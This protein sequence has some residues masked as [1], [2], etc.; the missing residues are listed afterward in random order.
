M[1]R[2]SFFFFL[3]QNSKLKA[4]GQVL[5]RIP[6]LHNNGFTKLLLSL[7]SLYPYEI[8]LIWRS[9]ILNK[10]QHPWW[11][12]LGC[13]PRFYSQ[14]SKILYWVSMRLHWR[15]GARLEYW[16][17]QFSALSF[18][19]VQLPTMR[20]STPFHLLRLWFLLEEKK[21]KNKRKKKSSVH[22][23]L[24]RFINKDGFWQRMS[25]QSKSLGAHLLYILYNKM[26]EHTIWLRQLY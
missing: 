20:A 3:V 12:S 11:M 23:D 6:R 13:I 10:T 22:A 4:Q 7:S 1:K 26:W 5:A 8:Q 18:T 16:D 14:R 24:I 9:S 17:R 15:K 2:K 21:I 25:I 19:D